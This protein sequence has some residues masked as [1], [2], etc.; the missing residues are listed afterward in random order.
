ML[1]E[2]VVKLC[3]EYEVNPLVQL[4]VLGYSKVH[5]LVVWSSEAKYARAGSSVSEHSRA[6][7]ARS[8]CLEGSQGL[9]SCRVEESTL[10]GIEIIDILQE[11]ARS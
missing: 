4:R 1:V 6:G 7:W 9:E 10:A 2:G 5:V 8:S 11:G 3:A